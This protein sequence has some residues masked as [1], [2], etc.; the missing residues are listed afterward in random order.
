MCISVTIMDHQKLRRE[1]YLAIID[2]D[3]CSIFYDKEA[4]EIGRDMHDLGCLSIKDNEQFRDIIM[5]DYGD[6]ID[7]EIHRMTLRCRKPTRCESIMRKFFPTLYGFFYM[8]CIYESR[9]CILQKMY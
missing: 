7:F 2:Y 1:F 6:V 3:F 8:D 5:R 9:I 4:E